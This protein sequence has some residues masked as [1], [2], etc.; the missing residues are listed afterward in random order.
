MQSVRLKPSPIKRGSKL[1]EFVNTVVFQYSGR[2]KKRN[3]ISWLLNEKLLIPYRE[4]Q[5][6]YRGVAAEVIYALLNLIFKEIA[7][8]LN[9]EMWLFPRIHPHETVSKFGLIESWPYYL[10]EVL[11]F[12][13]SRGKQTIG[14]P[15]FLDPVQCISFYELLKM[16]P[17]LA[18]EPRRV[19]EFLG[20]LT[21]RNEDK[22]KL[23][24][25]I[26]NVEFLRVEMIY[27]DIR[28]KIIETRWNLMERIA[29]LLESWDVPFRL[30][31]G[32][33]CYEYPSQ[34]ELSKF[35]EA[36]TVEEIPILDIEV[37]VEMN[38]K[39]VWV[40]LAGCSLEY[41]LKVKRFGIE[42]EFESGC[43]GIGINRFLVVIASYF[44]LK[45]ELPS[46]VKN[47]L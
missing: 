7:L 15:H 45:S 1:D 4:G 17:E 39:E 14:E 2:R 20:G 5:W 23:L 29:S 10:L 37:P 38:G 36:R 3:G 34:E 18:K 44:D 21:F 33:G 9:F 8:P 46:E 13:A 31:I 47:F 32:S 35:Y 6:A 22:D 28:R 27:Y 12:D 25:S 11:P 26:K 40:E 42:T 30:V 41:E 19:I 24:P 43:V 16:Y